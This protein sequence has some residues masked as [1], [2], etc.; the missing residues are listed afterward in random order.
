MYN[1]MRKSL[2]MYLK[3]KELGVA[4][5]RGLAKLNKYYV[6]A[7]TNHYCIIATG[8]LHSVSYYLK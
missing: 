5:T 3:D 4:A 8:T 1:H 2:N 6:K 7:K